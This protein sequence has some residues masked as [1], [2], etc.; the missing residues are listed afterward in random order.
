MLA[1]LLLAVAAVICAGLA[2]QYSWVFYGGL[3]KRHKARFGDVSLFGRSDTIL[4]LNDA[5]V[6]ASWRLARVNLAV[7]AVCLVMAGSLF[8]WLR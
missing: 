4:A 6:Y 7:A 5:D 8:R 2:L 3:R 1:A